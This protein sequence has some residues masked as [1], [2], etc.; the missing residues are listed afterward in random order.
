M[1][2]QQPLGRQAFSGWASAIP[3]VTSFDLASII[4]FCL[5]F[6]VFT[7]SPTLHCL[8]QAKY[9]LINEKH[10]NSFVFRVMEAL[11]PLLLG[12]MTACFFSLWVKPTLTWREPAHR[13]V[14]SGH[15][16]AHTQ[17]TVLPRQRHELVQ[18]TSVRVKKINWP[19]VLL[20]FMSPQ[21]DYRW[22][23]IWKFGLM[24]AEAP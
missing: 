14:T 17:N 4:Y 12:C 21:A 22:I 2:K 20:C 3:H 5:S 24:G 6:T 11:C 8:S 7:E 1:R 19:L 16:K 13:E 18:L 15:M 23:T 10:F 9:M